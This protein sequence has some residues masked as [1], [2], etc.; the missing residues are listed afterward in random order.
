MAHSGERILYETAV[1]EYKGR[2]R[3]QMQRKRHAESM[4]VTGRV[5]TVLWKRAKGYSSIGWPFLCQCRSSS[6]SVREVLVKAFHSQLE[7]P[8][9]AL[10]FLRSFRTDSG[11]VGIMLTGT[12]ESDRPARR[13]A[14]I[15]PPSDIF[16]SIFVNL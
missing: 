6:P 3:D 4:R 11:C 14:S 7:D 12:P 13:V 5:H 1:G 9:N 2:E 8:P 16:G 10:C 15:P